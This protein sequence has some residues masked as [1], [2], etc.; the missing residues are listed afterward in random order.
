MGE[1]ERSQIDDRVVEQRADIEGIGEREELDKCV[2][3][4]VFGTIIGGISQGI[5][6]VAE[7]VELDGSEASIGEAFGEEVRC[8]V[9]TGLVTHSDY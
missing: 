3:F 4:P 7:G 5:E 1:W 8:L 6:I 9:C 2:F